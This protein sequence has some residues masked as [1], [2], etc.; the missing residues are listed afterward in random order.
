M[1]FKPLS[2]EDMDFI[3]L[4]SQSPSHPSNL[5]YVGM[6]QSIEAKAIAR[7]FIGQK[8]SFIR[9]ELPQIDDTLWKDIKFAFK[10]LDRLAQARKKEHNAHA[11]M[12][13]IEHT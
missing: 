12:G 9:Q 5:K 7:L 11:R 2:H 13:Y 6:L 1:K 3:V 8:D 10:E 4:V